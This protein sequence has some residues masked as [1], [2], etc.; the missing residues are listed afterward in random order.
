MLQGRGDGFIHAAIQADEIPTC[1][2][3][4]PVQVDESL[5]CANFGIARARPPYD[6]ALS[7]LSASVRARSDSQIKAQIVARLRSSTR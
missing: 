3:W 1:A 4:D 5:R 6:A 7:D 2:E